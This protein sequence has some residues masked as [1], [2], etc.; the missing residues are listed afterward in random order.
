VYFPTMLIRTKLVTRM[1]LTSWSSLV[2]ISRQQRLYESNKA[3][4]EDLKSTRSNETPEKL[5]DSVVKS[6]ESME[7]MIREDPK[8]SPSTTQLMSWF[9]QWFFAAQKHP[10]IIEAN[11]MCLSTISS[12][13]NHPDEVLYPDSR[14]VLLKGH[15]IK[16]GM[17]TFFTNYGS[18]KAKQLQTFPQC[19]LL[20]YWI[21]LYAAVRIQGT[22]Q[23]TSTQVSDE[24][25]NSR[26]F[27]SQLSSAVSAQSH[28]I[29]N[30]EL[31][32]EKMER[33][34]SEFQ[35]S[36][37]VP[38]P[39]HWGGYHVEPLRMEFWKGG[40]NRFHYRVAF[41]KENNLVTGEHRW[42]AMCLQP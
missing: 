20:F 5:E 8:C 39:I 26:P 35:H 42:K 41:N 10:N 17:F 34:R 31:L 33:L 27:E 30:R 36:R 13:G 23:Q 14:Y 21:P 40:I 12:N 18:N 19:S 9:D 38:R 37:K 24:Y 22:V 6:I 25:W 1:P 3:T 16:Q 7:K 32:V 11:G 2:N 29:E 15:D 4:P 28:E